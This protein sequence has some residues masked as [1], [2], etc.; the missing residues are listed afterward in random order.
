M[1]GVV[2]QVWRYLPILYLSLSPGAPYASQ[3]PVAPSCYASVNSAQTCLMPILPCLPLP[4]PH[5][6]RLPCSPPRPAAVVAGSAQRQHS[7]A[8]PCSRWTCC[9][10]VTAPLFS[11]SFTST[12]RRASLQPPLRRASVR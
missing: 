11:P 4:P 8:S 12:P 7:T 3:L 10:V 1:A 2:Q 6:A 9:A 5:P